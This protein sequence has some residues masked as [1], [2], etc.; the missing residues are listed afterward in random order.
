[1]LFMEPTPTPYD[2]RWHLFGIHVRVQPMFWLV[3]AVM[4]WSVA[5]SA[6]FQYLLIWIACSFVSI[7]IH[8]LGHVWMGQ[9]FGTRGHIVLYGF[10]GLAIG[11]N[12]LE[13]RWQRILV[14][15]AGPLAGFVFLGLVL[16]FLWISNPPA[17]PAYLA[18]AKFQFGWTDDIRELALIGLV[19]SPMLRITVSF[20]IFIN[21]LWGLVNLLPVWPLDGGQISRDLCEAAWPDAGLA[22]SLGISLVVAGLLAAH[23]LLGVLGMQLVP[24]RFGSV[25]AALMF[26]ML[27]YQSFQMMQQVQQ[28]HREDPWD[29]SDY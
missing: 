15:A 21:L 5:T 10:G 20:L 24:L 16:L 4:G 29:R 11:S 2:L 23:C 22:R 25:Y 18:L 19:R 8:E 7:L 17:F 12:Q 27:A 13:S 3:S 9:L 14:C 1:M 26:G 6:G 28:R